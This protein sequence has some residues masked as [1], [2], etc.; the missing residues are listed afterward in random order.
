MI[1][2]FVLLLSLAMCCEVYVDHH[3]ASDGMTLW[4]ITNDP[5]ADYITQPML[6]LYRIFRLVI[7]RSV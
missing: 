3:M 5:R 2:S 1:A 4:C 7:V 6:N